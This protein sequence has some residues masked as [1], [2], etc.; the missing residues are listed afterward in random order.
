A[1]ETFT[2]ALSNP[3]G[4]AVVLSTSVV[5]T[6][7]NDDPIPT[8]SV[9]DVEVMESNAVGVQAIFT[10]ALSAASGQAVT[11]RYATANATATAGS[12]Y[13]AVLGT[14]T[15]ATGVTS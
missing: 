12:D 15:F 10:V 5:G 9:A 8:L 4:G 7:T 14:L 3:T 11:V 2:L 1:D 13:T 6:I